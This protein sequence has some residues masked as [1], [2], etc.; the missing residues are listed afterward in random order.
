M[1]R[2][3]IQIP[4]AFKCSLVSTDTRIIL[5]ENLISSRSGAY[6][7][8]SN[9]LYIDQKVVIDSGIESQ[10]PLAIKQKIISI[11]Q[12]LMMPI[13]F[14]GLICFFVASLIALVVKKTWPSFIY[15]VTLAIWAVIILRMVI[16]MIIDLTSFPGITVLYMLPIYPMLILTSFLSIWMVVSR[17][18]ICHPAYRNSQ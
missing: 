5:P 18:Y 9:T 1:Q 3:T 10:K 6:S 14:V 8:A 15:I 17:D 2:F 16:L 11:Y 4:H 7:I 12:W 13:V